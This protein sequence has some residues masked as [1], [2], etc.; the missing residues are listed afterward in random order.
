MWLWDFYFHVLLE[1]QGRTQ[2]YNTLKLFSL[3]WFLFIYGF[4]DLRALQQ[5]PNKPWPMAQTH[6][7]SKKVQQCVLIHTNNWDLRIASRVVAD[8]RRNSDTI[9]LFQQW[10]LIMVFLKMVFTQYVHFATIFLEKWKYFSASFEAFISCCIFFPCF[11]G[12]EGV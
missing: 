4:C 7:N 2:C 9:E 6:R 11:S 3:L 5:L 1:P 10:I 8:K 12:E